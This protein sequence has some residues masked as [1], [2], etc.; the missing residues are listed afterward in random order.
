MTIRKQDLDNLEHKYPELINYEREYVLHETDEVAFLPRYF[1]T[2]FPFEPMK[3]YYDREFKPQSIDI[4]FIGDLRENQQRMMDYIVKRHPEK[5]RGI[6][7]AFPGFGK[8]VIAAY[9]SS[10]LKQKTLI[11][12]DNSK[13]LEQW[14]DSFIKFTNI[15]AEEIGII[16]GKKMELDKPIC[17]AMVQTLVS[18]VKRDLK[19]TYNQIRDAGFN[20]VFADE[21]HKSSAASKF[22]KSFLF[23]NAENVIGLSATPY[24]VELSRIL[25]HTSLGPVIYKTT[26]YELTPNVYFI[27]YDS[28][29]RIN[30]R[31]KYFRDFVKQKTLYDREICKS[32]KYLYIIR[33]LVERLLESK[34][35]TFIVCSTVSQVKLIHEMLSSLGIGSDMLYSQDTEVKKDAQVIVATYS[36]AGTGFDLKTMSALIYASP[37]RGKKSVIQTTGRI[38]RK[39]EGKDKAV[40]FDLI[41][42]AVPILFSTMI[43]AKCRILAEEFKNCKFTELEFY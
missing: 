31:M 10:R 14:T 26:A 32:E 34:L 5:I 42:S 2:M 21:C 35:Q 29:L 20:V 1:D 25:M 18:K 40:V 16:K 28:G 11:L 7:Q 38:L 30:N 17:I 13:L 12:L 8:T 24:H 23:V 37:Y 39:C 27:K 43:N 33:R 3:S 19:G 4:R 22:A 41:D 9:I 36:Y 6:I 15:K